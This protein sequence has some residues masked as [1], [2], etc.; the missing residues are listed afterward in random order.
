MARPRYCPGLGY[1]AR[2]HTARRGV[3]DTSHSPPVA[4]MTSIN[5]T[6]SRSSINSLL[7]RPPSFNRSTNDFKLFA[8]HGVY[9]VIGANGRK[10]GAIRCCELSGPHCPADH[11]IYDKGATWRPGAIIKSVSR[12]FARV[13]PGSSEN[14]PCCRAKK[15]GFCP[16]H[17]SGALRQN[18]PGP[19]VVPPGWFRVPSPA[20]ANRFIRRSAGA[21][22]PCPIGHAFRRDTM[23]PRLR[24]ACPR[25]RPCGLY[26]AL[27][28][29]V[30]SDMRMVLDASD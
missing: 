1:S 22:P 27:S 4:T 14:P 3:R 9:G 5:L 13:Y 2:T 6:G 10:I 7:D 20:S 12:L 23:G 25:C 24:V 29:T 11:E 30:L 19:G 8:T 26:G 28:A 21:S 18:A 17:G 16:G 15:R